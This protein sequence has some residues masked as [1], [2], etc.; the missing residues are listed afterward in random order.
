M[1]AAYPT[2][3]GAQPVVRPPSASTAE[4]LVLAA[5][6][7]QIIGTVVMAAIVGLV[8]GVAITNPFP[9]SWVAILVISV[10]VVLGA[11]F[12]YLAYD[13][14]YRRIL[15][16]DYLGAQ[17]PT[18]VFGI[19]SLFFGL[20]PG[21]LYIVGYVKLADAVRELQYGPRWGLAPPAYLPPP[22]P[23]PR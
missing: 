5:L 4:S 13:L 17:A 20:V 6:V 8:L 22:P 3:P 19:L 7:L 21:I 11:V 9:Y 2:P 1:S 12:V 15:A 10:I 18:L 14:S 16:G 23:V